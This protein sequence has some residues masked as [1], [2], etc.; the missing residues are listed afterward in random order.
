MRS[1]ARHWSR[2]AF[3]LAIL[4]GAMAVGS[5]FLL[6]AWPFDGAPELS[7]LC[8]GLGAY[9]HIISRRRMALSDPA[10]LLDRAFQLNASGRVEEAIALLTRAIR[11][12]PQLWQAFQY[13]GELYLLK[14]NSEAAARDFSEAIRLAPQ[15]QHLYILRERANGPAGAA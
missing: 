2:T 12:S 7:V 11:Q 13:R 10:V 5:R 15:E 14:Q 6:G 1:R 8:V 4:F 3:A 9:F